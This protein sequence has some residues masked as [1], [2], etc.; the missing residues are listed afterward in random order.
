M[1]YSIDMKTLIEKTL[2]E[3]LLESPMYLDIPLQERIRLLNHLE[4]DYPEPNET[5]NEQTKNAA[6]QASSV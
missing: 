1:Q 2:I 5:G 4:E 6:R 3:I